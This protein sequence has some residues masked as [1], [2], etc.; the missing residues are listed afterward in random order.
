MDGSAG[1]TG[2]QMAD[3]IAAQGTEQQRV[4][5]GLRA[6]FTLRLQQLNVEGIGAIVKQLGNEIES[7]KATTA[8]VVENIERESQLFATRQK[9]GQDQQ[10][11]TL[12]GMTAQAESFR[13]DGQKLERTMKEGFAKLEAVQKDAEE[14]RKNQVAAT[15]AG[16]A[17]WD[18]RCKMKLDEIQAFIRDAK[19]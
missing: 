11:E 9:A 3:A 4:I 17:A 15:D 6:D 7:V 1:I 8:G 13:A 19:S 12:K 16:I 2:A 10:D 14:S 5:D 18:V